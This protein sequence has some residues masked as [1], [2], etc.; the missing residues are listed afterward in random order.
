MAFSVKRLSFQLTLLF[1]ITF[2]TSTRILEEVA[3]PVPEPDTSVAD[4]FP[5]TTVASPG[6][7]ASGGVGASGSGASSGFTASGGGASGGVAASGSGASGGVAASGSG[8]TGGVAASGS[9]V[10]AA[11]GGA[12][13]AAGSGAE[14]GAVAHGEHPTLVFFMHDILGGSNPTAKAITGVVSNPAVSGQV[15]FAK[16]NGAVLANNNGVPQN[17]G[18]SG[19]MNNNNMPFLTGLGGVN[20]NVMQNNNGGNNYIGGNGFPVV[21]GAQLGSGTTLQQL[22]FGT[23]IAVDDELTDGH[24]LNSGMVGRAQ[25]FYVYSSVDG[26]TQTMLFTAMF[27]EGGYHN[28]L[29]FFGIH[30]TAVSES[31]VSVMGGTG[32]YVNAKGFATV[33]TLPPVDQHETD[34]L[35]SVLEFSVYLTY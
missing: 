33:K 18:N 7:G 20:P 4:V 34:G 25:G 11:G 12:A 22:M 21:N 14:A 10:A 24:A 13:T 26:K 31:V 3:A 5:P 15:P 28:S 6:G 2:A 17:N 19:I 32:K 16:P 9:G 29:N 8:A 27:Q 30:Q 35:E 23:M 1:L